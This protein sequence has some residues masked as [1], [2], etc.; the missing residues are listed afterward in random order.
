MGEAGG[1]EWHLGEPPVRSR[2]GE[3]P[4]RFSTRR[5]SHPLDLL[6][7]RRGQAGPT[8]T[9][10]AWLAL[11][12]RRPTRLDLDENEEKH[13]GQNIEVGTERVWVY[14][15]ST[16]IVGL[17]VLPKNDY[18]LDLGSMFEYFVVF[19]CCGFF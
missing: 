9:G 8:T 15:S 3:D 14:R 11:A 2:T 7:H 1:G 17:R 4:V 18:I 19:D 6:L 16:T 10:Q 12:R 5:G 13:R